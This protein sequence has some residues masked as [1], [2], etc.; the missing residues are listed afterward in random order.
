MSKPRIDMH[1]L[2]ELVRLHRLGRQPTDVARLLRMSRRTERA[3][4]LALKTEGLLEGPP[5]ELPEQ[6]TLKEA[7]ERHLPSR[8]AAH[9]ASSAEP[10]RKRIEE[11]MGRGKRPKVIYTMLCRDDQRFRASYDAVYR[12]MRRIRRERGVRPEDVVIPV[13]SRAGL[14]AQIDFGYVGLLWDPATRRRRK[15]WLWLLTLAY[16]RHMVGLLTFDQREETWVRCHVEAFE[17]LGAVPETLVPDNLK[18]AVIRR[19]FGI[20]EE[21]TLNRG[22]R[23]LARHYGCQVDP[24]PVRSPE[25]KGR[26]ES[27][28]KYVNGSFFATRDL[29]TSD[30]VREQRELTR[31][32]HETAGQR[33]HGTTRRRPLVVFEAEERA[34][35]LQ[36]PAERYQH[37]RWSKL[38]VQRD[39]HVRFEKAY[40]SVP[41][42]HL[43]Q[44]VM[45]CGTAD[46]VVVYLDGRRVATHARVGAG[47]W[48][49]VEEHLPEHRAPYRHR[50]P[51][52]WQERADAIGPQASAYVRAVLEQD[53]V[54]SHLRQAQ[55]AVLCLERVEAERAE[56]ACRRALFFGNLKIKALEEILEKHLEHE[57]LPAPPDAESGTN[58]GG[59]AA[60]APRFARDPAELLAGLGAA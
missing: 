24:T 32:L 31:W 10:W 57:P 25:K 1:R 46:S 55:R 15:T 14:L 44:E 17:Q 48:A 59:E 40:Y 4:R 23:E 53:A 42:M 29:A 3:Y 50:D 49:T 33:T 18:S 2:Q 34:A 8:P 35:L 6:D 36:L 54:L 20:D 9:Q 5:E 13:L 56:A 37:K 16:S 19:A 38:K 45:V 58:P 60:P 22:Y 30:V 12:L 21:T 26:V 27:G 43:Q 39:S 11:L 47:E 52:H 28:V 7:V 51:A 41:F